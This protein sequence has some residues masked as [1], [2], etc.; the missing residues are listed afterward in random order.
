MNLPEMIGA[1]LIIL[2]GIIV[3]ALVASQNP[4]GDGI[5]SLAGA[6]SFLG[7]GGRDRS[8]DAKINRVVK[9]LCGAFF[10]LVVVGSAFTIYL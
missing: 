9:I 10:V 3:V 8:V 6:G 1:V 5:S 2:A 4:K 7:S